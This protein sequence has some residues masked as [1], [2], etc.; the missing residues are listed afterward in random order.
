MLGRVRKVGRSAQQRRRCLPAL[1]S[2]RWM[3]TAL[4]DPPAYAK[5]LPEGIPVGFQK[6]KVVS[7]KDE[8]RNG[9]SRIIRL[10]L[11]ESMEGKDLSSLGAAS[12]VKV[13]QLV[14][15]VLHDKSY[16]PIS[17]PS[18]E[19]HIDLLVKSY[20]PI[21]GK[22]GLGAFLCGRQSGD[23]VEVKFKPPRL[24]AGEVYRPN[25]WKRLGLIGCGTGIAPL[26]QLAH[27]IMSNPEEKTEI[28]FIS[29]HRS[30]LDM[31]MGYELGQMQ[32]KFPLRFAH[33]NLYSQPLTDIRM[34]I[35]DTIGHGSLHSPAKISALYCRPPWFPPSSVVEDENETAGDSSEGRENVH[36]VVCGTDG[37]LE[38]VC[39]DKAKVPVDGSAAARKVQGEVQGLLKEVG[40]VKEQVTKL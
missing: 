14:D 32:G 17:L 28:D 29:C 37:F 2:W 21:D 16:S 34:Y 7:V 33:I 18:L 15:G 12:G 20:P 26:Y 19:G 31:L 3:T 5:E 22:T 9:E 11:P 36:V 25:R 39:G 13:R 10:Q 8:S 35:G 38:H 24:F 6:L 27:T 40:F 4:Y 23:E 30:E 1:G